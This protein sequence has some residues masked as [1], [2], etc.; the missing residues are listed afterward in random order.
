MLMRRSPR[1][2]LRRAVRHPDV[3]AASLRYHVHRLVTR[4]IRTAMWIAFV[5]FAVVVLFVVGNDVDATLL[6]AEAGLS[7]DT[8]VPLLPSVPVLVLLAVVVVVSVPI[9]SVTRGLRRDL[10]SNQSRRR[11][12]E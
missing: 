8:V 4:P 3:V 2:L 5:Y 11:R 9:T 7:V 1:T 12:L 6:A 10:R